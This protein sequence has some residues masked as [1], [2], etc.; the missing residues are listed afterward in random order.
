[1]TYTFDHQVRGLVYYHIEACSS[2]Q[3]LLQAAGCDGLANQ[4]LV[5]PSGLGQSTFYEANTTRGKKADV[6][7]IL[8]T[9]QDSRQKG[10]SCPATPS[11]THRH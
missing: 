4:L 1:M 3:D 6:R 9:V 7:V 5:P 2:A 8:Q 10:R 11:G